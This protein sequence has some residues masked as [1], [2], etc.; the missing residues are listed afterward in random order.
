MTMTSKLEDINDPSVK[1][2]LTELLNS[3]MFG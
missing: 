2:N 1:E 3:I